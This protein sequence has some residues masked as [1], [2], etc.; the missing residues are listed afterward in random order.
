MVANTGTTSTTYSDTGLKP[1][2]QYNYRVTAINSFVI[3]TSVSAPTVYAFTVSS[4]G[5]TDRFGITKIHPTIQG[6]LEWTSQFDNG[7]ART[8]TGIDPKDPWSDNDHGDAT[9]TIN[10]KGK[11]TATGDYVRMYVHNPDGKTEWKENLEITAYITRV[12]ET[13]EVSYSGTQIFTRTNHGVGYPEDNLLC[14]D[15]GYGAKPND[16]GRWAFE[17]E[18]AHHLDNGY[19][20]TADISPPASVQFFKNGM[21]F[22]TP[23]GVKYIIYNLPGNQVKVELWADLTNGTNGGD[24]HKVVETT[25]T[26]KNWGT[27]YDV[28]APGVDP[29]KPLIKSL[30]Q[31]EDG[32]IPADVSVYFRHEYGTMIYE[33]MSVREIDLSSSGPTVTASPPA[34]T[35]VGP[36]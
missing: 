35:Y 29:A 17:K 7:I 27:G 19:A 9:Y 23:I 15:R 31:A 21:P 10:G 8:F 5:N 25:D 18:T 28:C 4:T 12:S 32:N 6:G 30:V 20:D 11:N 26:G 14:P 1:G 34:G 2:T 16:A 3:G 24:W 22:N 33:R 36:Q 13:Q